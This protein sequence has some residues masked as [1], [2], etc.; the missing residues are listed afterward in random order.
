[1]IHN[2]MQTIKL[3]HSSLLHF[4]CIEPCIGLIPLPVQVS[5]YC[6]NGQCLTMCFVA[7][8]YQIVSLA[9]YF[10]SHAQVESADEKKRVLRF[11]NVGGAYFPVK[12]Q[13]ISSVSLVDKQPRVSKQSNSRSHYKTHKLVGTR[14][15]EKLCESKST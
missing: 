15:E 8:L 3:K 11:K 14:R 7:C 12:L 13:I 1:M 4:S 2:R 9:M 6:K 5:L 10:Q